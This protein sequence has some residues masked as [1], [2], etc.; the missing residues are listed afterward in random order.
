[1]K[2]MLLVLFIIILMSSISIGAKAWYTSRILTDKNIYYNGETVYVSYEIDCG[3][4]ST[5]DKVKVFAQYGSSTYYAYDGSISLLYL[6]DETWGRNFSFILSRT[7]EVQIVAIAMDFNARAVAEA[8]KKISVLTKTY[9][10][11]INVKDEYNNPIPSAEIYFSSIQNTDSLGKATFTVV[12]GQHYQLTISKNGY[13]TLTYN[14][15]IIN[16]NTTL[17]YTLIK[18]QI[19]NDQKDST[20]GFEFVIILSA[21]AVVILLDRKKIA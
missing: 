13:K 10:V 8:T 20:P 2:K 1:M 11:T 3:Y 5:I 7:G 15:I 16:E 21:I 19:V 6:R 18:E 9:S 17:Q 14:N 12:D 4:T